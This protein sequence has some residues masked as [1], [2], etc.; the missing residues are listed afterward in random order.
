[1]KNLIEKN[2]I[3]DN[4][5]TIRRN[6]YILCIINFLQGLLFYGA[7]ATV[8]RA[9]RGLTLDQMILVDAMFFITILIFEIPLGYVADKIGYKKTMIL[10]TFIFFITKI[11]FFFSYSFF[12]FMVQRLLTGVALA[13]L[14]GCDSALLYKSVDQR[15]SQK[16]FG[17]YN[18]AGSLGFVLSCIGCSL[19]CLISIE[20]TVFISIIPYL[21][22]FLLSFVI[23]DIRY[24]KD[25]EHSLD[26]KG[27][28]K[29]LK[30]DVVNLK[31]IICITLAVTIVF[32]TSGIIDTL[33]VPMQFEKI[34]ITTVMFG[35]L[36]AIGEIPCMLC[37][38]VYIITRKF[39]NLKTIAGLTFIMMCATLILVFTNGIFIS[40][41]LI[42]LVKVT[43]M[44]IYPIFMDIENKS[45]K[46]ESK[47]RATILSCYSMLSTIIEI[48]ISLFLGFFTND[49]LARG[50]YITSALLGVAL[51][52]IVLIRYKMQ[53][54]SII[55]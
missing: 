18:A 1:M 34:G 10:G 43:M 44:M 50:F 49:N 9:K 36:T 7:I 25:K 11:M 22:A 15:D 55:N 17:Y 38:K 45:I 46:D 3:I 54:S 40:L 42:T 31:F 35:F 52:L 21:I 12:D 32:R 48:P 24:E 2:T 23:K 20:F 28:I 33:F 8:F 47:N 37:S 26:L 19:F 29:C 27:N 51:S 5:K 16:A 13:T 39:G 6:Y 4:F 41:L 14:S 30:N 53:K